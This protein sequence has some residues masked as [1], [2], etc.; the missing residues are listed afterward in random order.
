MLHDHVITG[1]SYH[2]LSKQGQTE[3]NLLQLQSQSILL[4]KHDA[5]VIAIIEVSVLFSTNALISSVEALQ[6][7]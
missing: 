2:L 6:L 7:F 3:T 4:H 1:L 5:S